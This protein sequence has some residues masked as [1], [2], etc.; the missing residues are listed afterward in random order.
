MTGNPQE[1]PPAL[2]PR[3]LNAPRVLRVDVTAHLKIKRLN[4]VIYSKPIK[5]TLSFLDDQRVHLDAVKHL[6]IINRT[7]GFRDIF[8]DEG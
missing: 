6:I 3:P 4:H 1:S 7:S 2:L 8:T 5:K